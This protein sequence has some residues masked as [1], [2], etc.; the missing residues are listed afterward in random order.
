MGVGLQKVDLLQDLTPYKNPIFNKACGKKWTSWLKLFWLQVK[1]KIIFVD[2]FNFYIFEGEKTQLEVDLLG[3]K[4]LKLIQ[5]EC[6][7]T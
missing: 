3:A 7:F 6:N 5:K 4:K 2:G 1:F